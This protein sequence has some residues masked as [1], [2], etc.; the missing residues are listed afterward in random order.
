MPFYSGKA[1]GLSRADRE[2]QRLNLVRV[3]ALWLEIGA[4][5]RLYNN[6]INL[7]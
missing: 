4:E 5:R 6:Q 7:V 1:A 2:W 3:E